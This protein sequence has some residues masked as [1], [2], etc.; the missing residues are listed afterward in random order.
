MIMYAN[1]SAAG[2]WSA[3]ETVAGSDVLSNASADQGPSIAVDA[4][5][6]PYVLYVSASKGTFGP[7]GDTAEYGAIRIKE[8][9]GGAWVAN[10]PTPDVLTHAPQIYLHG[11]DLYG[12]NGHD[13][14]INFAYSIR[15]A[16]QSWTAEQ[17]LSTLVTD[18][19]ASVRWDPL[20]ETDASIIDS[21]F[22]NEDRLANRSFLGEIYYRAVAP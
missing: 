10:G 7:S 9:V 19:A 1:L 2:S 15:R 11:N 18:G 6:N 16:G 20:H 17:K 5:D 21:A 4:A 3:P 22:Y 12:F 13:T 14:A 8:R